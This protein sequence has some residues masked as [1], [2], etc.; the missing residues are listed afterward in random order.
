MLL[1]QHIC[2]PK[3][4]IYLLSTAFF[5]TCEWRVAATVA[6]VASDREGGQERTEGTPAGGPRGP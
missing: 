3:P 4:Y 2:D 6:D 1:A 5:P